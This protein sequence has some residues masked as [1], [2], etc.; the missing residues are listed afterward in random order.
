MNDF[1]WQIVSD[2][3]DRHTNIVADVVKAARDGD[4]PEVVRSLRILLAPSCAACDTVEIEYR[5]K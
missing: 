4:M 2:Y 1:D 3:M 5:R